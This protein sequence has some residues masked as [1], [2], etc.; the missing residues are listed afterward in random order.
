[1]RNSTYDTLLF[2]QGDGRDHLG[3]DSIDSLELVSLLY[4][5]WNLDVPTEDMKKLFSVH[6]IAEYIRQNGQTG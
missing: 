4:D 2:D 3:L 6:A 1:M 5:S